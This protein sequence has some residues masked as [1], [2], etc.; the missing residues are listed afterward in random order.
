MAKSRRKASGCK[1][2]HYKLKRMGK[3]W[4]AMR[5]ARGSEPPIDRKAKEAAE[6]ERKAAEAAKQAENATSSAS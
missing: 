4:L 5:K 1:R 2:G 6:A 3:G